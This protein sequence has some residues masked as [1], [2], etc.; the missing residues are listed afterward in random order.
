MSAISPAAEATAIGVTPLTLHIG[1]E[2]SG[3]DLAQPLTAHQVAEINDALVKWKVIFFRDQNLDHARHV[4]LARQFGQPTIGH[5]VFGHV[6]GFP[7]IYSVAKARTANS[8]RDERLTTPWAGWHTD[9]TAA[10]N[11]PMASILRGVTIPPFGG[12]T[13]WTN[14]AV[15]YEAL[16]EPI[17]KLVDGLRAIHAF[18]PQAGASATDEYDKSVKRRALKSEHPLV[19]V[20]PESGERLLFLSPSFVK[21][22]V[23]LSPRES[24]RI[25]EMLWEH[26]VR[27]E[28]T[29]RFKW[30]AG[31]IAMWDNRST[32]HLAPSDIFASDMDRQLYRI[33][34]VGDIPVGI[35]GNPSRSLE[36][37][38]ILSVEEELAS[39]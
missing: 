21:S 33:T 9:I 34:L 7:E 32:A 37:A 31:D 2:I 5:A 23:G 25:L 16:S 20:H 6:D 30:N 17:K 38:P 11:P 39:R 36:G 29:V 28:F 14:L 15:A 4:A 19:T 22:I 24:Q 12:D 27:P 10:I 8:H 1:A 35:D 13:M 3:V 18:V 26:L